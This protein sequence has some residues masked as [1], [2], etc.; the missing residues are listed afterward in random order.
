MEKVLSDNEFYLSI[1]AHMKFYLFQTSEWQE[2]QRSSRM[3]IF[4]G[5]KK[6][7]FLALKIVNEN[8]F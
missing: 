2:R 4:S 7:Y 1:Y 8:V 6:F 5:M 3:P